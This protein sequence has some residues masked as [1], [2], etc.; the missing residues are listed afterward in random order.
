MKNNKLINW[1]A[2]IAL[3][4]SL[5]AQAVVVPDLY[6]TQLPVSDLSTQTMQQTFPKALLQILIKVTGNT[7]IA[8]LP[9]IK[10]ALTTAGTVVD[11]Y[12]YLEKT[13]PDGQKQL[14][15]EV[16]FDPKSV[17]QLLTT[18]NQPIWGVNRPLILIWLEVTDQNGDNIISSSN[19]D[20]AV[21][22][23]LEQNA[24]QLGLPIIL[25]MMDLQDI[26]NVSTSDITESNLSAIKI[27]SDRYQVNTI[28]LGHII[29]TP[30]QTWQSSWSLMVAGDVINWNFNA[31]SVVEILTT[32]TDNMATALAQRF[33]IQ[34][35]NS[36]SSALTNKVTILVANVNGLNQY[37]DIL[38]YLQSLSAVSKATVINVGPGHVKLQITCADGAEKLVNAIGSENRLSAT[39]PVSNEPNI[40]LF[41]RWNGNK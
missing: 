12:N 25:P 38:N 33:A 3:F 35:N 19:N 24:K 23:T 36:L 14:S 40:N 7:Q 39:P 18:T 4:W 41:Y 26:N 10:Q 8:T 5:T 15:L 13:T 11:K 21:T 20:G 29:Q 31:N 9:D 32:L 28:V 6:Q 22:K 37:A 17:Q 1:L 34:S 30:N 16:K 27:A 2:T